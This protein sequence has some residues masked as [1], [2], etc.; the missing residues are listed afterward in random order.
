MKFFCLMTLATSVAPG[1]DERN[2][3]L[4]VWG[5]VEPQC[6]EQWVAQTGYSTK[7]TSFGFS[8]MTPS[9]DVPLMIPR[10]LPRI[11]TVFSSPVVF[12]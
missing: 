7:S 2:L 6:V 10:P 8:R 4:G 5:A 9:Y 12:T 11:G 1:P 3:G